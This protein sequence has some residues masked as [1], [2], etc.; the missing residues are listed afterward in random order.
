MFSSYRFVVV[1]S[2]AT[3]V[4]LTA[5][6]APPAGG[7]PGA[8]DL[9]RG[10]GASSAKLLLANTAELDLT[11]AQVVKLAAIARRAES[12]RRSMRAAMDSGRARFERSPGDSVARRQLRE[13]IRLD[14]DRERALASTDQ[15]DAIA[16]LTPDQQS[17]A[18]NLVSRRAGGA[19]EF[20]RG[21]PG[22]G[23]GGGRFDRRERREFGPRDQRFRDM[24]RPP[25]PPESPPPSE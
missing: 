9:R 16:V 23:F 12:R 19:R 24:P 2:L 22:R 11:D 20:R 10:P 25:R 6:G 21:G 17:R 1:L 5:Q 3:G 4:T 18:W 8:G 7:P 13:R 14:F 15:R